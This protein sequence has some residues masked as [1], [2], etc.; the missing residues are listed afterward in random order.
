MLLPL[1]STTC[2]AC[3]QPAVTVLEIGRAGRSDLMRAVCYDHLASTLLGA[4]LV[5]ATDRVPG[6]GGPP[7]VSPG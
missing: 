6:D 4:T 1:D 7:R 5:P 2:D 3:A